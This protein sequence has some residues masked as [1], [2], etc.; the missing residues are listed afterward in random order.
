MDLQRNVWP[1]GIDELK[2]RYGDPEKY[3]QGTRVDARWPQMILEHIILP[4]P[5]IF[6]GKPVRT[7]TCHQLVR[8]SLERI[9]RHV[10]D[11]G[12]EAW[13]SLSPYGGCYCWRVQRGGDV[14]S[15][16]CWGIAID[17]GTSRNPRGQG[18]ADF[19]PAVIEAFD[20]EGWRHGLHFPTPDPMHFQAVAGY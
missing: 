11:A 17:L 3:Q 6:A 18:R 4:A 14:L 5:L 1:S 16:H 15:T 13:A 19:H 20:Y 7:I 9:L 8:P 12:P 10:R 2:A